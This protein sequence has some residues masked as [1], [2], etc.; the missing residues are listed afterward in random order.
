MLVVQKFGGSSV[1]TN[2]R[3]LSVAKRVIETYN[4]GHRVVVVLSA[5]GKTTNGLIEQARAINPNHSQRE[6]DVLLATG[7][8]VSCA[9]MAMA[10]NSLG[11]PAI[12][13]TARQVSIATNSD[14]G[15]ARIHHI[16][17]HRINYE[18]DKRNI[19]VV[20]GF[21]GADRHGDITTLGRGGSDTTAVAVACALGADLCEIYT[22]VEGVYTADPNQ[23]PGA[24][25]LNEISYD[26]MLELATLGAK[27]L[28]N[29]SVEIAKKYNL[30]LV[31]RSSLSDTPGTV[32]KEKTTMEK[33][34][35]AGITSDK[36]VAKVTVIG[37]EDTP[38]A[39]FKLFSLISNKNIGV[40][41]IVQTQARG[42]G[43][44]DISFTVSQKDLAETIEILQAN[45]DYLGYKEIMTLDNLVKLSVVGAGM[46]ST[47]GIA[48]AMFEAL[49]DVGVNIEVIS[50]SEIKISVLIDADKAKVAA[51]SVHERLIERNM[52]LLH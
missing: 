35:I 29:R 19:V 33:M 17:T 12:S 48:T 11:A 2:E 21:Q 37:F 27:V 36:D 50:T 14:H 44:N 18:L 52:D 8:Q 26:E 6:L 13:L 31:V 4:Q 22:D 10:L 39:A 7:E 9:L 43:S 28:H 16:H 49:Y 51:A 25:K 40:D 38:G 42:D 1:A 32:I 30:N 46:I 5:M 23:I 45:Q 24:I 41:V 47:P 15:N 20:T 3:I 34:L